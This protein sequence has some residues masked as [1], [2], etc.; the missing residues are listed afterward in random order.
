M[1]LA[2]L[3]R[4]KRQGNLANA[5]SANLAKGDSGEG[6]ALATL[7]PLALANPTRAN[8]NIPKPTPE[9]RKTDDPAPTT[10]WEF[11]SA[12]VFWPWVPKWQESHPGRKNL[13][14]SI[15]DGFFHHWCPICGRWAE[16]GFGFRP[17]KGELGQ[18]WCSRHVPTQGT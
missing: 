12:Y 13:K 11:F 6:P 4:G 2:A 18:W 8:S 17:G 10:A 15:D 5:N 3:I 14:P 9:L 16:T 1:T 7:A